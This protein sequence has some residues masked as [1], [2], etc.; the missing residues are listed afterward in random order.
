MILKEKEVIKGSS[1]K[2]I[3]AGEK[4][5]KDVAFYLRRA[6][7][8]RDDVLVIND[9]RI[10]H[11]DETAQIDHLVVTELGF[12]LIESKSIKATVNIN[13][14]GEWSRTANGKAVGM[15][16][17]I[18]QVELQEQ[19]LKQML[20]DHREQIIGT[21][22]GLQQG[23][24]KRRWRT[25]CAVSSDAVIDRSNLS[26]ELCERVLKSEFVA[27][28]VN[29]NAALK[30]G[31]G[32][33]LRAFKTGEPVFSSAELTA[34]GQFLLS[35]H[36]PSN[37]VGSQALEPKPSLAQPAE[38]TDQNRQSASAKTQLQTPPSSKTE[39]DEQLVSCKQCGSKDTLQGMYGKYGYYVKCDCGT[40][41]SMKIACPKCKSTMRVKKDKA[42]YTGICECGDVYLMH[43]DE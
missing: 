18:K 9:L 15:P 4:Q 1:D 7:K 8:D 40:N 31:F 23:F 35:K 33:S 28:W 29:D 16:S 37:S 36:T 5:E 30:Q 3:V 38:S 6:F 34:I 24:S 27:D 43:E 14:A 2:R 22:L 11:N 26:K 41:T 25:I 21:V 17:P 39:G 12:C 19:L 10:R 13:K 20:S 42:R 32:K